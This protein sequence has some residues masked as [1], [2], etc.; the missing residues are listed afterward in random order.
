MNRK[1]I[2][3]L[4]PLLSLT[5]CNK[6]TPPTSEESKADNSSTIE[7]EEDSSEIK[8]DSLS[9]ELQSEIESSESIVES[10]EDASENESETIISEQESETISLDSESEAESIETE[11]DIEESSI[12]ESL[13]PESDTEY[14]SE[15]ESDIESPSVIEPSE[16]LSES[17]EEP[18]SFVPQVGEVRQ[19]FNVG[20][21]GETRIYNYCPSIFVENNREYVYFCT[22]KDEGNVTDYIGYREGRIVNDK[23]KYTDVS[24][25]VSHGQS[26]YWDSRHA[27]DPSVVKGEFKFHGE[28]YN[29]LMAYLGCVTSDCTLNDT[30]IAV[31]KTPDGPWIKCDYKEDGT[32]KINPIVSYMDESFQMKSNSWGTGQPSLVSVDKKGKVLMFTT[33]GAANGTYTNLR[34]Y[35]FSNIDEYVLLRQRLVVVST[36]VRYSGNG[37]NFINNADFAYDPVNR[38]IY[39]VKGRQFFGRDGKSPDMVADTLDVYYIDD[40][41]GTNPGDV[42]FAG[43]NT[44]KQWK[45]VGTIDQSVTGFL[46]NHNSCLITDPYAHILDMD[47]IGVAFTR[48]D[49]GSST[50]WS[51]LSTYRIYATA[52]SLNK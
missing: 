45:L 23:I 39:M 24:Y 18:V 12:I 34:E 7:S 21:I 51:Y 28:T 43:N 8:S 5:S 44:T 35:D 17:E 6:L 25:V 41:E 16:E 11:T 22:N 38:K 27:C 2:L 37:A 42:I 30:G 15:A 32:T 14:P 10:I 31:S 52:L 33:I 26:G 48:S 4:I 40:T 36:G 49:E 3:L 50:N 19:L 13:E 9:S 20:T 46:R 47:R 1:L 29:Y